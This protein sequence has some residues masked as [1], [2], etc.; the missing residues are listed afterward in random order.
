QVEPGKAIGSNKFSIPSD[1]V[2]VSKL[3][4]RIPRIWAPDSIPESSCG[5]TEWLV[6]TPKEGINRLFLFTICSSPDFCKKMELSATGTTG[7]HQRI[8]PNSA[9]DI[10]VRIPQNLKEQIAIGEAMQD[11]EAEIEKL[12]QRRVKTA[13]LKQAMMQDLLA[14][15]IRLI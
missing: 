5:S 7:S 12:E 4:P 8:S 1:A 11:L 15:R 10:F 14:G 6:L 3:N 9:L 13:A 2:L